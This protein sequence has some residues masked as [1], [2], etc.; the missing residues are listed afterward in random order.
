MRPPPKSTAGCRP[1]RKHVVLAF[2]VAVPWQAL[3]FIG[4]TDYAQEHGDWDFT[5]SP[6]IL[7][8]A[9]ESPLTAYALIDFNRLYCGGCSCGRSPQPMRQEAESERERRDK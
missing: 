1:Q 5:T 6:P 7:S 3:V 2:P 4:V 8:G 9:E